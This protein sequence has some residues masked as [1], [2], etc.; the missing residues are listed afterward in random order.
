[1]QS[2]YLT[3]TA[4]LARGALGWLS[5]AVSHTSNRRANRREAIRVAQS[6]AANTPLDL[7][8]DALNAAE[9]EDEYVA[10][11]VDAYMQSKASYDAGLESVSELYGV[12]ASMLD[13][14][15][16]PY[17]SAA[18]K[19]WNAECG[20]SEFGFTYYGVTNL[21]IKDRLQEGIAQ[22]NSDALAAAARNREMVM[23]QSDMN[24]MYEVRQ[25][26]KYVTGHEIVRRGVPKELVRRV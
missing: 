21:R 17:L 4:S 7:D 25:T 9:T 10:I 22:Q 6:Q 1:M 16:W 5:Y 24:S 11:L 26:G 18:A 8:L 3:G 23:A 19:R 15:S 12:K 13:S 14:Q 2:N 20:L